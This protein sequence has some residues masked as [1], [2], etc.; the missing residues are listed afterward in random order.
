MT[1]HLTTTLVALLLAAPLSA[2]DEK[3][4]VKLVT[5]PYGG[6]I[7]G[8]RESRLPASPAGG[9]L[10]TV[11]VSLL[12]GEYELGL[13]IGGDFTVAAVHDMQVTELEDMAEDTTTTLRLDAF[14]TGRGGVILRG[15]GNPR[16]FLFSGRAWPK[17]EPEWDVEEHEWLG[18]S[19]TAYGAGV[20]VSTMGVVIEGRY[21]VDS[22]FHGD[23]R[24]SVMI[25]I[26]YAR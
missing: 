13:F 8:D 17:R 23:R 10:L 1:R 14:A 25:L 20:S 6:L 9:A 3:P 21:M 4:Q 16:L 11:E 18:V 26:G 22:R 2:Q 12:K 15:P 5:T 7:W 19:T 24:K